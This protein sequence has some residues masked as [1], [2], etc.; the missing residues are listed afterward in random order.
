M[1]T[2]KP[3]RKIPTAADIKRLTHAHSRAEEAL[4]YAELK[5]MIAKKQKPTKK[6]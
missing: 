4:R 5:M 1:Q 6:R 2:K 3:T